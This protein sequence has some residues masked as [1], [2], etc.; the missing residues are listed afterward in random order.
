MSN[1]L[2]LTSFSELQYSAAFGRESKKIVGGV[3]KYAKLR[4]FL[5]HPVVKEKIQVVTSLTTFKARVELSRTSV[6]QGWRKGGHKNFLK[7]NIGKI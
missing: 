2:C 4:Y 5:A 6:N 1:H 3:W 7:K